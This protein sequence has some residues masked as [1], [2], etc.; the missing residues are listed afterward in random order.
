MLQLP[1]Q[2][3]VRAKRPTPTVAAEQTARPAIAWW[4]PVAIFAVTMIVLALISPR[5]MTYLNP[6]TGDEPFYLMTAGSIW[7]DHDINECNDYR[8]IRESKIYPAFYGQAYAATGRVDQSDFPAGWLGWPPGVPYPLPPHPAQIVPQSRQCNTDPNTPLP[9]DPTVGHELYSKHG[10]GLSLLVLPAYV[11]GDRPLTVY[12]LNFLAAIIAANI[13]L[14][15]REGTRRFWPALLTWLA[16]SFTVP[17][18]PYSFLIFP[19]LPAALFVIYAFRRIRLWHNNWLQI[20]GIGFSIAFLPWLH[21]RFIPVSAALFLYYMW[22]EN[23]MP[24]KERLRNY[25]IMAAQVAVSAVLLMAFF[26]QRYQQLTPNAADHAGSSDVA[27]TIRGAVGS[28]IDEQWG[29]FVSA[30]IYIL[31]IVGIILMATKR[32]W[33]KDLLW[34]GIV[35]VPYFGVIANYAQW[36][37]EW[38]PPARYL[39]SVLPLMALPF[40]MVIDNFKAIVYR[41]AYLAI[42]AVLLLASYAVMYGFVYQPRWMYNQPTGQSALLQ[43]GLAAIIS[44]FNHQPV[45]VVGNQIAGHFLPSFVLPYFAYLDPTNGKVLGDAAVAAAWK[46]SFWPITIVVIIVIIGLGL[47]WLQDRPQRPARVQPAPTAPMSGL[48]E[49][50]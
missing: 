49:A 29:L 20:V 7:Y 3:T 16:L 11:I 22:Q 30:P 19:E 40:A 6:V 8:L 50:G 13:Y 9:A 34:L 36:W 27:G 25:I 12:F 26:Y 18:M 23:S 48:P 21:Y 47:A 45:Q 38:C 15:A 17:I 37:G 5:I 35:F 32:Q 4:E 41:V 31:A 10:L 46:A 42:Y 2:L 24:T 39:A 43:N 1:A 14:F 28:L 44:N 33:R